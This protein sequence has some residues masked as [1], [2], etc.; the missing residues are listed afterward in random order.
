MDIT[1]PEVVMLR[2]LIYYFSVR[3]SIHV[4][5]MGFD[6][7]L[8]IDSEERIAMW[9]VIRGLSLRANT[10]L[11]SIG[12][13][14]YLEAHLDLIIGDLAMAALHV[15]ARLRAGFDT[16][17]DCALVTEIQRPFLNVQSCK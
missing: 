4:F 7:E 13:G 9:W 6:L 1:D 10:V 5:L 2:A 17:S 16:H 3:S 12:G 14:D 8:Y 15:S 11:Q